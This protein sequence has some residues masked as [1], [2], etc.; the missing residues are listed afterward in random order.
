MTHESRITDTTFAKAIQRTI[1]HIVPILITG[2]LLALAGARVYFSDLNGFPDQNR[3]LQALQYAAKLHEILMAM[4]IADMVLHRIRWL[5]L[6]GRGVP[7]GYMS[8]AY[9]LPNPFYLGSTEFRTNAWRF[10]PRDK[11]LGDHILTLL[12]TEGCLLTLAVG[13]SSAV[14]MVSILLSLA[15]QLADCESSLVTKTKLVVFKSS[16]GQAAL[17]LFISN[18]TKSLMSPQHLLSYGCAGWT[19]PSDELSTLQ[20]WATSLQFENAAAQLPFKCG[21]DGFYR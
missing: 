20:G 9:Q 8:A 21:G 3:A 16:I 6:K 11:S 7:F 13:P 18:A 10:G 1:V 5:L 2:V 14:L 19:C 15:P 4:S 17:Q 12:I